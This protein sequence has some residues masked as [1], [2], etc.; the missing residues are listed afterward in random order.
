ME[1]RQAF[2]FT[3]QLVVGGLQRALRFSQDPPPGGVDQPFLDLLVEGERPGSFCNGK[4][5]TNSGRVGGALYGLHQSAGLVNQP[6]GQGRLPGPDPSTGHFP[7]RLPVHFPAL[8][9]QL[10]RSRQRDVSQPRRN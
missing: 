7:D 1:P 2:E 10:D 9:H 6:V 5:I 4:I 3:L 8:R